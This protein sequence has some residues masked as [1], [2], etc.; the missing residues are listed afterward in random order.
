MKYTILIVLLTQISCT[1]SKKSLFGC[2]EKES[3]ASGYYFSK[4]YHIYR[5]SLISEY[6]DSTI[7]QKP[8]SLSKERI[9]FK[10]W[11]YDSSV[12]LMKN[13]C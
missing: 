11:E 6:Y 12:V 4:R 3:T 10:M 5:D 9:V 2:W 7:N 8:I 13:G 1:D